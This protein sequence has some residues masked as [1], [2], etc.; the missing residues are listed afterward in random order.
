MF[1]QETT[2]LGTSFKQYFEI[3]P[4]L[5]EELKREAYRVRHSVYCEDL[6]FEFSRPD[7]F[8]IDEYD[9]HSLHLLIRS[10]HNDAFIGCTRII[11]PPSNS[12]DRRLPFEKTCAQTLDYSIIDPSKLPE[13]KIGEVSRLAVIAAFR[14]RKGEKNHPINI[15][16]EDFG[17]GPMMRFPYIPLGLYI[18]TIELARLYDIRVLFMLTEERLASHFS[19]L[20]AQLESIGA[21]IE[22]HGLRF[23][24]MVEISNIVSSMRPIF[25][26]LY[27]EIAQ[28]I[29]AG[30]SR[31]NQQSINPVPI[32]THT[33]SHAST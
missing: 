28:D 7:K 10:I 15:S 31:V 13:D 3:V 14:R 30:M 12:N 22:H 1:T 2:H 26:P 27:R 16:K 8:E 9:A 18:G 4:A 21:P 11:R 20:G 24:S 25:R 23:P 5:T 32:S 33:P 6:Q 19:R 29:K 17:T